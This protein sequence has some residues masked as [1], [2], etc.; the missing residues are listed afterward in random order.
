MRQDI[1]R[2]RIVPLMGA[3]SVLI[4]PELAWAQ[5]G[6]ASATGGLD[7]IVVTARKREENLQSAPLSVAAFS[8]DTLARA[9]IDEFA[10]IAT[11][12]PGFTLNPDN[13][14][15]PNIFLRGIGTDI[16]SAASSAAIG[17]FLNDVYLPRA[18]GTAI[19]LFDLERVEI[20]RGPQGTLYG[21]NVVGG[22]INFITRKPTDAFRAG[23]EAGIGN[24]G[25]FD[26]KAT[27]AGG[28]GEGLS[29]SLAA[30]AR[31][32]DGF[33]FN[34]FTGNDVEDLSAFGL[35]G[36]LRY[37]PGDSLDIL[38]TGDLTR[39]R[40]R[41]KWV[42]I[43]TPS[44]HNIPFVNPDPRRG[45]NNV[46]G[47]Q[48][49]DLGGIHLSANWD[50]GAG[51]LTLIS[52]YREGDFS[53]LNNDAGSFIDFTRLVYDGNGRID[54]LAIDRSRFNDDYFINDKDAIHLLAQ[55]APRAQV[56]FGR[57]G[58]QQ[59][60]TLGRKPRLVV[61]AQLARRDAARPALPLD[62]RIRAGDAPPD[63]R[64]RPARRRAQCPRGNRPCRRSIE[65]ARLVPVG[66]P[67]SQQVE[68]ENQRCLNPQS[69]RS[70][71]RAR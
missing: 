17:F 35:M 12:V 59:P 50:S 19:E 2:R 37:Q 71:K 6:A 66:L 39:R 33:A 40:A 20:V 28:I 44:T 55:Q 64:C 68:S 26:V 43:Q 60:L 61:P 48:D 36:Q 62:R 32:R 15:E 14:S 13:V 45:P 67:R 9:G 24:Y 69:I 11:R 46:D 57:H 70:N 8:G 63:L 3:L 23:V 10:E 16:E 5:E 31:R 49:A 41:G 58:D 25:S 54:F 65:L 38:L 21:K 7:E 52:A 22:A 18:S 30:A 42:D 27:I 51:T 29:G 56:R 4:A 34:S 47:R 53:V 1:R